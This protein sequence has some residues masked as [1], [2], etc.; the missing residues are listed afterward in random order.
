VPLLSQTSH[1]DQL[2]RKVL[3]NIQWI[4]F[5]ITSQPLDP[6]TA[7]D[8]VRSVAKGASLSNE[9][10]RRIVDRCEG[11][12]LVLEE[13]TRNALEAATQHAHAG[14]PTSWDGQV[15]APLQLVVQSRLDRWPQFIPIVQLAAVLGREFS[16]R[17]LEKMAPGVQESDVVETIE[18]LTREGLFA[19]SDSGLH[20]RARFKH[21]II[22][23]AVYNTL[24]GSDRQRLHS[25]VADILSH[26]YKGTP[27]TV[28]AC[29]TVF[30][31]S[32]QHRHH[33]DASRSDPVAATSAS[34]SAA[35]T[36]T[37]P[38]SSRTHPRR[39]HAR[40]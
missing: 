30:I 40:N 22:C 32:M 11:V 17:M 8:L 19:K 31:D 15:L 10:V 16:V 25:D 1:C 26:D 4:D 9:A 2:R 37:L 34:L 14:A 35:S 6:V 7:P 24:L 29:T 28:R 3:Y 39:D 20:D 18:V 21:V 5:T 12:P 36:V 13:V 33:H 38:R 23:E 27:E